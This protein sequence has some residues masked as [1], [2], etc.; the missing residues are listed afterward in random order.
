MDAQSTVGEQ[1]LAALIRTVLLTESA[2]RGLGQHLP[3]PRESPWPDTRSLGAASLSAMPMETALDVVP[4]R[5]SPAWADG[6]DDPSKA[7]FRM[8]EM[9][10]LSPVPGDPF[11]TKVTGHSW[12]TSAGQREAVRAS[13]VAPPGTTLAIALPTGG[14]KSSVFAVPA[15]SGDKPGLTVVVVPTV[16]LAMD[17]EQRL[18]PMV[19]DQEIARIAFYSGMDDGDRRGLVDRVR[20]GTQ[21]IIVTSPESLLSGL[22]VALYVAAARGTL[23]RLVI[24]EAHLVTQWGDAF[25]PAYQHIA[26]LWR[27]LCSKTGAVSESPTTLL[28][29]ATFTDY[30]LRVLRDLF[31]NRDRFWLVG[32]PALRPEHEYWMRK[33]DSSRRDAEVVEA[34][35][36][37][38]RPLLVYT[39]ERRHAQRLFRL[40]GEAGYKRIGLF[41]GDTPTMER[42]QIISKWRAGNIDIVVGTSAFG[43]GVDVP[44]VRAVIH[45]TVPES[46]DRFYQEV[47]RAGRDGKSA[48]SLLLWTEPDLRVARSLAAKKII[49]AE[50]ARDRWRAMEKARITSDVPDSYRV[51]I[52]A[53]TP[54]I[55]EDSETNQYWNMQVLQLMHRARMIELSTEP[56]TPNGSEGNEADWQT[57]FQ[58]VTVRTLR[59]DLSTDSPWR[60]EFS[61]VRT[62]IA[63]ASSAGYQAMKQALTSHQC[64]SEGLCSTYRISDDGWWV[65]PAPSCG[66]CEDCRRAGRGTIAGLGRSI[67]R[68]DESHTALSEPLSALLSGRKRLV[69]RLDS[70]IDGLDRRLLERLIVHGVRHLLVPQRWLAQ[71]KELGDSSVFVD[72]A[73]QLVSEEPPALWNPSCVV[74]TDYTNISGLS[75]VLQ[76][77][78]L[79]FI[80][81]PADMPDPR[82]TGRILSEIEPTVDAAR[83]R[84]L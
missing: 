15:L 25:R 11:A 80:A 78:D 6:E 31:A 19:A 27:T 33:A 44:D 20:D 71:A 8:D 41:T 3:I 81:V 70:G 4:D 36:R 37:F 67:V 48:L 66:G 28:L 9:Q 73:Q 77:E 47:G 34:V 7:G 12:Y 68:I 23:R 1:D 57:W 79:S 26:A 18:M 13:V 29:S 65:E 83:V 24:D 21:S 53:T 75:A 82:H 56:T 64:L 55:L 42:E 38:P 46:L 59:G 58:F 50:V 30:S 54:S 2:R 49:T 51:P 35:H 62:E 76:E 43:L 22:R 61:D 17:L 69:I 45:A 16:S 74:W 5:W 84:R 60:Q 39:T 72:D 52:T 40:L 63:K 10:V 14:G 32:Q